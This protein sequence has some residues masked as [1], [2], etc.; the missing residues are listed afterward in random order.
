MTLGVSDRRLRV[1]RIIARLNVGGPAIHTVLLTARLDP[2][3]YRTTLVV[4]EPGEGEGDMSYLA[5]ERGVSPVTIGELGRAIRPTDDL[6]AFWKLFRLMRRERPH[7]VHT[8]TAKAGTLG[9]LAAVAARVPVRV[10]TF[11]GHVFSGYFSPT[12]TRAFLAIERA[13]ARVTDRIIAI[14]ES[15]R[16]DLSELYRVAPD[17][18]FAVVPLGLD[19][20]RFAEV[21]DEPPLDGVRAEFGVQS[22]EV[23]VGIVGRLTAIKNHKLFLDAAR[24]ALERAPANVTFRFLIVG[25]GDLEDEIREQACELGDRV[26]L[27][28]WR[29]DLAEVYAACDIVAQ[30]SNNDGTPVAVIEALASGRPV[31]ATDV[32]GVADV[33]ER[34]NLGLL[35]PPGDAERF[36]D[37]LVR[38]AT[39]VRLQAELK[40]KGRSSVLADR[41]ARAWSRRVVFGAAR[42]EKGA[43]TEPM[44]FGRVLR[45]AVIVFLVALGVRVVFLGARGVAFSPDSL[46]YQ[47]LGRNIATEGA[48]SLMEG[49]PF[50][51]TIRRAPA[52]PAFLALLGA[53]NQD[54]AFRAILVQALFDALTAAGL[55][56]LAS[57]AVPIPWAVGAGIVYALHPGEIDAARYVLTE[58]PFTFLLM[59]AVLGIAYGSRTGRVALTAAG[60]IALGIAIL[61]RPIA[62][63]LAV[64]LPLVVVFSGRPKRFAAHFAV[65][66]GGAALVVAPWTIRASSV[67]HTFVLVQGHSTANLYVPTR[68]DWNQADQAQIWTRLEQDDEWGRMMNEVRTPAE[69]VEV[70]RIGLRYAIANVTSNPSAYLLSRLE[71]YPYLFL[72]SFDK[73]TGIQGS[74]GMLYARGRID[75]L[76]IKG[77]MLLVF[78]LA[79]LVLAVVGLA[80]SRRS[81]GGALAAATWVFFALAH[82][83]LWIEYRFWLPA[84]PFMLVG[85]AVGAH[86]LR[87]MS[88]KENP[89][90]THPSSFILHPSDP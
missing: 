44:P 70:D 43:M 16:R 28:G 29:R 77:A 32:G 60:G 86:E 33:L 38:L 75:L 67:S 71:T 81:T 57:I 41:R 79:P 74:F 90:L 24:I 42:R 85:A 26:V 31:V 30:T 56:L 15:Q 78:A 23:V 55:V 87:R 4:G 22:A 9:R 13:L 5:S 18:K 54:T 48:Y 52:Y 59:C 65:F 35:V 12:K 89:S 36:A 61:T 62:G 34:G 8:H 47:T 83:P 19:L 27:A 2:E 73:F 37:A 58:T 10:H 84:V 88:Q 1:M 53:T 40:A 39:D 69:D 17:A 49:P 72:T 14:S 46:A 64:V 25:G 63:P 3:K 45:M 50:A 80:Q 82:I 20:S 68:Y 76:A 6:V 11:H 51:P 21:P 7:V 66:V